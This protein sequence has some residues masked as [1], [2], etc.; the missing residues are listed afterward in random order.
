MDSI[1]N[2][3]ESFKIRLYQITNNLFI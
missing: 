3:W 2:F 1:F